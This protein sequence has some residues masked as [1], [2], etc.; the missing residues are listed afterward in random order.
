MFPQPTSIYAD[1]P[2]D[3]SRIRENAYWSESCASYDYELLVIYGYVQEISE[4]I[5]QPGLPR[6]LYYG[7]SKTE[8]YV[9]EAHRCINEVVLSTVPS[10][11]FRDRQQYEHGPEEISGYQPG[12]DGYNMNSA[13]WT[14]TDSKPQ[15]PPPIRS[16]NDY[17][18]QRPF[19]DDDVPTSPVTV[20]G[21]SF[22]NQPNQFQ[23]QYA[24]RPEQQTIDDFGVGNRSAGGLVDSSNTSGGRFA[25]FPVKRPV[26]SSGGYSLQDPPTLGS[27]RDQESSFADSIAA[28]LDSRTEDTFHATDGAHSKGGS[29]IGGRF[30]P[31]PTSSYGTEETTRAVEGPPSN[32]GQPQQLQWVQHSYDAALSSPIGNTAQRQSNS[33][34]PSLPPPPPGAALPTLSDPWTGASR[35]ES[36][37]PANHTRNI[38]EISGN[39]DLLAYMTTPQSEPPSP[40]NS[41][42]PMN[43]N[44]LTTANEDD[45]QRISRHVR[46]GDIKDVEEQ[47]EKR[48]SLEK[49]RLAQESNLAENPRQAPPD[50][51][52]ISTDIDKRTFKSISSQ[53]F[54]SS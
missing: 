3:C 5:T 52:P 41:T 1:H 11:G 4:E 14:P 17:P 29:W 25:T 8:N 2:S 44:A 22:Q 23:Q 7:H 16:S 42:L 53:Q 54:Y 32:L 18:M 15:P 27:R 39:Y 36:L 19:G 34:S 50:Y 12:G 51:T 9:A 13:P 38:S 20:T 6:S 24:P 26:G 30:I 40:I 43:P 49:A 28:A 35:D 10:V 48:E 21:S 45:Q 46:F 31:G 37:Q 47:M 33:G